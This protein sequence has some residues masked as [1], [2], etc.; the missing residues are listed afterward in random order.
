MF[1]LKKW[2]GF[3][4][5]A[6]L[7]AGLVVGIPFF[8]S[9]ITE[10]RAYQVSPV[11][12]WPFC[13]LLAPSCPS[14]NWEFWFFVLLNMVPGLVAVV[15]VCWL[16]ASFVQSLYGLRSRREGWGFLMRSLFG[17]S[18]L[19]PFLIIREG[20]IQGDEAHVLRRVGGP[21]G[22]VIFND[23][24]VVLERAGRLTRVAGS[25]FAYLEPFEKVWDVID[26]RPQRWNF[27]VEAMT[28]EG[29]PVTCHADVSFKIDDGGKKSTR[30]EAYPMTEEAVFKAATSKWIREAG[31]T[32]PDRLMTWTKRV[33]MGETEGTLRSILARYPLDQLIDPAIRRKIQAE[34]EEAL[35]RSVPNLGA[36]IT[37]VALGDIQLEDE[38]TQQWIEKW[39]AEGRRRMMEL[40]A[41]GQAARAA[42]EANARIQAQ[43]KMIAN[44]AKAFDSMARYGEEIPSRF[45]ILRFIEMIKRT[46]I[47]MLG[48]LYLPYDVMRTFKMLE[49][50]IEG[51]REEDKDI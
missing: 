20:T 7:V 6:L 50:G 23:S 43:V 4:G 32:E 1:D 31:R 45:V 48:R 13:L 9:V 34:L 11:D 38:I 39:Q 29:I 22:L 16:A 49:G 25:G 14:A 41:E 15:V 18:G 40:E 8:L 12:V 27:A 44:T 28:Q 30:E 21:G 19:Q 46:S 37:R 5:R 26:L 24:A 47:E 3:W 36:K 17:L 51:H 33:V 10:L 42:I 2:L 35:R